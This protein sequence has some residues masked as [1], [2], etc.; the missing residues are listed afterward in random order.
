MQVVCV[1]VGEKFHPEYVRRLERAVRLHLHT[2]FDFAVITDHPPGH[3]PGIRTLKPMDNLEGWWQK[4]TL[5]APE[6]DYV[7]D[8]IMYLDLD[9]VVLGSLDEIVLMNHPF[10]GINDRWQQ[11]TTNTSFMVWDHSQ[12]GYIYTQF[13]KAK[14]TKQFIGDQNYVT[15]KIEDVV[16]H[17]NDFNREWVQS[18]KAE[19]GNCQTRPGGDIRIC[20]FHGLPHPTDVPWVQELWA[21][22]KGQR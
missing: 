16:F 17:V 9:T 12:F 7:D 19:L 4:I 10:I 15:K 1:N 22:Q 13:E 14:H 5:F 20:Y 11:P 21:E 3:Y 6:R 2:P 18:Y 8:R